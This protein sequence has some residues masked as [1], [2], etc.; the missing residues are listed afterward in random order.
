MIDF[1]LAELYDVETKALNQAVRRNLRRFPEDFMFQLNSM[2]WDALKTEMGEST[3]G[4]KNLRS[5]FVTAN[6]ADVTRR[7]FT[8]Y[9]FTEPGVA[10]LSSVLK[11]ERAIDVNITIMRTF[12]I[13]RQNISNYAELSDRINALEKQTKRKFRDVHEALDYLMSR[14]EGTKIGF[15]QSPQNP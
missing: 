8:P 4:S 2:E 7:R 11:S 3:L 13:L 15:K 1:H 5:Q 6:S 9:A 10:M 12:I 14:S